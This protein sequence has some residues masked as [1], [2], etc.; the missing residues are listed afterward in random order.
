MHT[1]Q[2]TETTQKT[3]LLIVGPR[4][5]QTHAL[6]QL[7]SKQR[8]IVVVGEVLEI[9]KTSES[10]R[11][12][13]PDVILLHT[14]GV[15]F[16]LESIRVILSQ[17]PGA[18]LLVVTRD[19][20]ADAAVLMLEH[21]ARG[22]LPLGEVYAQGLRAIHAVHAGEIWGS[23]ALLSRIVQATIKRTTLVHAHEKSALSLTERESEVIKLLRSGLSNK[24]I[25]AQ[26]RISD[27]T[28]KT[29][30]QNIFG[31]MQIHRRQQILPALLS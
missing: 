8:A 24:E 19:T 23:R 7:L 13:K 12:L 22:L 20:S 14:L 3:R 28:V 2:T 21:G 29:H 25:A 10:V 17:V 27:K 6:D 26:L 5:P 30:L 31:K 16:A 9:G 11:L 18:S 1:T 15:D 4:A